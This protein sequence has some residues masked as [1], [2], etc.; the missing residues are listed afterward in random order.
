MRAMTRGV[1][2]V[3][4]A[5]QGTVT[6]CAE[7]PLTIVRDVGGASA[8]VYY[9]G[10]HLRAPGE[11][12]LPPLLPHVAPPLEVP[13]APFAENALLPVVSRTLS[14]GRVVTRPLHA[15]GLTPIFLIGD[16]AQSCAWLRT[17]AERLRALHA[18]GL[19]V[20]VASPEAL[21]S[22]RALAP[23]LTL[24]PASGDDL[25]QRLKLHHYPVLIT[26]TA[27]EQ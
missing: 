2:L 23:G 21:A 18:T 10:L 5:F 7:A 26:A 11:N 20:N 6:F 27:I 24:A 3:L 25:A 8:L 16:D 9:E 22:L 19:V 1:F 12:H 14:P 13:R 17:H 15:P 4:V